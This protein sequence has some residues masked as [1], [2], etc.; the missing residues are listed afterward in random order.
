[1]GSEWLGWT[2]WPSFLF[3]LL[4]GGWVRKNAQPSHSAAELKPG[5][6]YIGLKASSCDVAL[7]LFIALR[8]Q[9]QTLNFARQAD[10]EAGPKTW[11]VD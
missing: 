4:G 2:C 10:L 11:L 5:K 6:L 8:A 3:K 7:S 1:M 9:L